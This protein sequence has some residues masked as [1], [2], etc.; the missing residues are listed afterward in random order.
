MDF[1]TSTDLIN[2]IKVYVAEVESFSELIEKADMCGKDLHITRNTEKDYGF[3]L[4]EITIV[5]GHL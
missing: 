3:N 4:P 1:K 2:R 5:D